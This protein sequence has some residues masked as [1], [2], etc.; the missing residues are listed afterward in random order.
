MY[1]QKRLKVFFVVLSIV[2]LSFKHTNA[3][4]NKILFKVDNEIITSI[5]I[6]NEIR[7]LK[8]FN[9]EIKNLSYNEIFEISKN[10]IL[11][12]KIKKLEVMNFTKELRVDDRFILSLIKKKYSK[13]GI[14]SLENF[15]NY[16]KDKNLEV[17]NIKEKFTIELIWNDLIYQKF[18]KKVIIDKEKIK[19]EILQNSPKEQFVEILLSEITFDANNK[20]EFDDKYEK[21]LFD[22]EKQ[23]FKKTILIHS[24]SDTASK[25]G[26]IGW[27]KEANL[28]ENIK[29]A[30]S[31]LQIGEFSKPIRTSSGFIILKIEGKKNSVS[32]LNLDDKVQ[33]A[34][35][36]KVNDQ[37]NQFSQMYFNKLK[38]NIKIYGL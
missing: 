31:K 12:D 30:I 6:Y 38:K 16:F 24:N 33:E 9:P 35:N 25:G 18:I 37:L 22:I 3:L 13:M 34:I 7:F 21:I 8:T 29:K 19:N 4:E 10:S 11:R 32:K 14:N 5:D 1:F 23:G 28:N 36:F 17:E 15:E 2:T 20:T 26:L 27:V